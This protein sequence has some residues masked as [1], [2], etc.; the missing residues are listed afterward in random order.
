MTLGQK[1]K[2]LRKEKG[3]TQQDLGGDIIT[4][5]MISQIENGE[6]VP[7]LSALN[8]LAEALEVP[9]GY[10]LDDTFSLFDYR[11]AAF[12]PKMKKYLSEGEY[13]KAISLFEK[14]SRGEWD[15]ETAFLMAEL[16]QKEATRALKEGALETL[17]SAVAA[18]KLY[19]GRTAFPTDAFAATAEL[20][21]AVCLNPLVPVFELNTEKYFESANASFGADLF[22]YI[23]EKANDYPFR[24]V[25]Y[26]KHLEAKKEIKQGSYNR[27][28][29]LLK[30]IEDKKSAEESSVFLLFRVYTDLE[31]CY[32][33]LRLFEEAYR[34]SVKRVSIMTAFRS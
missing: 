6:A 33:E 17:K 15:D 12:L 21:E 34:Y 13:R 29:S 30:E 4:R 23:T 11:K 20:Y 19:C 31:F 7:S 16:Y 24:N 3:M 18:L 32:K 5:N 14:E 22:F 28:I 25:L 10:F 27:A 2:A 26:A 9:S 8:R 1:I